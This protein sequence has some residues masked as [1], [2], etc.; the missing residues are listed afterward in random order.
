MTTSSFW[1][2]IDEKTLCIGGEKVA[3]I[4]VED[5]EVMVHFG[6]GWGDFLRCDELEDIVKDYKERMRSS[7][8]LKK[9][10][11]KGKAKQGSN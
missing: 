10:A 11:W 4:K 3:E 9:G 7:L 6:E 2:D 1:V 5:K 8:A